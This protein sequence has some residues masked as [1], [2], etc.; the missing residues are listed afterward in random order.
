MS[1]GFTVDARPTV[2]K[3]VDDDG[4]EIGKFRGLCSIEGATLSGHGVGAY[5]PP[6]GPAKEGETGRVRFVVGK[7][8]PLVVDFAYIRH[9]VITFK[10]WHFDA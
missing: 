1:K 10:A 8:K 7:R 9:G 2:G 3:F 4:N 6:I 5:A